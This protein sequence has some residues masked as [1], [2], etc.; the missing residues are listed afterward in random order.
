MSLA[1]VSRSGTLAACGLACAFA[2]LISTGCGPFREHVTDTSESATVTVSDILERC[3]AAH[4]GIETLQAR[5]LLRDN[6]HESQRVEPISWDFAEPDRCRVQIGMNV[7]IITGSHWWFYDAGSKR[8]RKHRNF[9][10]TPQETAAYLLSKGV[11]FLLPSISTKGLAAFSTGRAGCKRDWRMEGVA[12][13][14]E[15]PCYV[16]SRR[17]RGPETNR[18]L[19]VWVDQDRFL[20][21]GWALLGENGEGK[22]QVVMECTYHELLVDRHLPADR[23]RLKQPTPITLPQ[24][25]IPR[26]PSSDRDDDRQRPKPTD[27]RRFDPYLAIR[28]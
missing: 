14:A 23:F 25:A 13:L 10:R 28:R 20:L 17:G 18:I 4:R 6:R 2:S 5:G 24:Q 1:H 11:P 7:A 19:R 15:R 8:Y 27:E 22:E 9:T 12:W 3:V 26:G 21:R 16:V